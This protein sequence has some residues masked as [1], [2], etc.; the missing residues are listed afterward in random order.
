M[1]DPPDGKLPGAGRLRFVLRPGKKESTPC[2][3]TRSGRRHDTAFFPERKEAD[4]KSHPDRHIAVSRPRFRDNRIQTNPRRQ[5]GIF[6]LR[7]KGKR[8]PLAPRKRGARIAGLPSQV[9]LCGQSETAFVRRNQ[10]PERKPRQP[11]ISCASGFRSR[12]KCASR[13]RAFRIR[14][15]RHGSSPRASG[16]RLRRYTRRRTPCP[17]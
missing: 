9:S 6:L 15:L 7:W 16:S 8:A 12:R 17:Q 4:I 10:C 13:A 11:V 5:A 1:P 3:L 2:H 14:L